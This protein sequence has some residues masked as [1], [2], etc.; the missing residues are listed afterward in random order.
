MSDDEDE[1]GQISKAQLA[2]EKDSR[3]LGKPGHVGG[4]LGVDEDA[5]ELEDLE[6]CRMTRDTLVK[7]SLNPWF[8]ELVKGTSCPGV[9][10]LFSTH[11]M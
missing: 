9:P 10:L 3:R 4:Y 5:I 2:D 11:E 7:H 6:R 8:E 1:D